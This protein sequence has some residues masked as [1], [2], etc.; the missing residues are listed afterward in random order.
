LSLLIDL[1]FMYIN[2]IAEGY[3]VWTGLVKGNI[4]EN[5]KYREVHTGDACLP[6]QNRYCQQEYEMSVSLIVFA[7]KSHTDLHGA[8][9]L[10]PI[11]FTLTMFN[12]AARCNSR[13]WR[14]FGYIPNYG[15]G[16]GTTDKTV[17]RDKI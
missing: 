7:N 14:P 5:N 2:N 16:K 6:A 8:L 1:S 15:F 9:S 13:F 4:P 12:H 11:I 10:T 17:T 3:D